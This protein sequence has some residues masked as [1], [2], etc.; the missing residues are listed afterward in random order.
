MRPVSA[1]VPTASA[2]VRGDIALIPI[3]MQFDFLLGG[4][5]ANGDSIPDRRPTDAEYSA[6]LGKTRGWMA[7]VL[8]NKFNG[9]PNTPSFVGLVNMAI[10]SK[11]YTAGLTPYSHSVVVDLDL[12]LKLGPG[13]GV[14]YMY[15]WVRALRDAGLTGYR[16]D[17]LYGLPSSNV[18]RGVQGVKWAALDP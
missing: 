1:P 9:D 10:T 12:K 5:D 8:K 4:T 2:I 17:Y 11:T 7:T 13:Q 3:K 6:W 14:P 16:T 15:V 18:F